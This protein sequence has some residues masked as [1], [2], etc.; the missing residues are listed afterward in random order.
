[1]KICTL[2]LVLFSIVL[3]NACKKK[4]TVAVQIPLPQKA[5]KDTSSFNLDQKIYYDKIL[6]ALVGSAIGDAMGA[7]TEMWYRTEIQKEYGYITGLTP[8]LREKSPEGT[9]RHNMIAGATTDDT[10]WKLLVGRYLTQNRDHLSEQNF[11][12]YITEYYQSLTRQLSNEETL[13]STDVLDE[14][15]EQLNWIK[16]WARLT[17]AYQ[18]GGIAYQ[19]VQNR[20]YGGEMSCAGMLYTPMF[21]LVSNTPKAAYEMAFEHAMFDIGYARDISGLVAAMTQTAMRTNRMDSI[22]GT[23][24]DVDPYDYRNSRLIGRLAESIAKESSS[25]VEQAKLITLEDSTEVILPKGYP[26]SKQDWLQE[27][28]IF[29]NLEK[30]QKAIAFHAG[31]IW[32]ILF[33]GLEFGAGD[34]ERTMQFIVNY[35]RDND[36]VAA[37]AGMILGAKDGFSNLPEDWKQE[38]LKVNRDLIGIDLEALAQEIVKNTQLES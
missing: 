4:N 32:Q 23:Y 8:A 16:E 11:A 18:E 31:E 9:W 3:F 26:G 1:M 38:I 27:A 34:F 7:S 22:L 33:T 29:S 30:R 14:K 24:N 25:F 2:T 5:I 15:L 10:R 35:G 19:R 37:V 6:G 36:T 12:K 21:G 13:R 20:F 28:H 17:L